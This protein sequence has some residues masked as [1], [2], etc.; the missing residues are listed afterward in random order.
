MQFL[1]PL[2]LV[3][4]VAAL[5][6]LAI[7]LLHRGVSRPQP[8]SNLEFLR[9]LHHSRM[10]RLQLRQWLILLVRTLIVGLI[11]LALARPAH[12]AG[13]GWGGGAAPVAAAVL[14]DRSY[15]TAFRQ[16]SGLIFEQLRAQAAALLEVFAERDE[17]AVIP[18]AG[19]PLPLA[20]AGDRARLA[21]QLGE[22]LPTQEATELEQALQAAAAHCA[23]RPELAAEV[24]LLTDLARHNWD[25]VED[26]R[27]WL[28]GARIYIADPG[29]AERAN[30]HVDEVRLAG[31]LA[32][33]GKRLAT[34]VRLVN[35]AAQPAPQTGV[36]LYLDG[37]RVRHQE[38]ELAPGA[39]LL[40]DFA[41]TPGRAGL[42][43]GYVEAQDDALLLD[44]RRYFTLCL[45]ESIQVLILGHQP[46]DTYYP[47]RALSASSQA[48]PVLS[49]RVGLLPELGPELLQGAQVALLCNV[50]RLSPEQID[51]LQE[52]AVQGGK[53]ILFPA[54]QADLNF[55]NRYLLPGLLPVQ[56]KG[57]LGRPGDERAF[58]SFSGELPHHPLFADLL[59][60]IPEDQPR[61][62]AFFELAAARREPLIRFADGQPALVEGWREEGRV[63]LAA[64][65]LDLEWSDLPLKGLFVPLLH[66]LV[67]HL[68]LPPDH[69]RAYVVGQT[70]RRHLGGVPVESRIQAEDPSGRRQWISAEQTDGRYYW[71]IPQVEEAGLWRLWREG[72]LVDLFAVNPDPREADLTPVPRARLLSLFGPERTRF[73]RPQ[74]ELRSLVLGSRYGRELW[75]EC[76]ALAL[77]L[78]LLELW[79]ARAP[80]RSS[81]S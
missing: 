43:G 60:A 10:R 48:D 49:L 24:F 7:H 75:R 21:Q 72:E 13:A 34:Q 35:T 52:F 9:R 65:P 29:I 46:E 22:L 66:R 2:A 15:S 74:D 42:I 39:Q 51:L 47:R 58:Q 64:F 20:E 23:A 57:V 8:F 1:N 61:F 70:V 4:L 81:G 18:F 14:L 40:L 33:P 31:W 76:L 44:N 36:D 55:Y 32:A 28:P 73:I 16:P 41:M 54:P 68:S 12:Q 71:K 27:Q 6:P 25:Q 50:Q 69:D 79:L 63:I 62:H 5:I 37:E 3:G 45:P 56:F 77:V 78:L 38:V 67:R 11:A 80:R 26:K 59:T 17:V 53:L 19:Q 30:L